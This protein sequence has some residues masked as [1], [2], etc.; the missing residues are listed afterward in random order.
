M[1]LLFC[2]FANEISFTGKPK[3]PRIRAGPGCHCVWPRQLLLSTVAAKQSRRT[4]R[5]CKQTEKWGTW[6]PTKVS[7]EASVH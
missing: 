2:C 4:F 5:W 6:Q 3:L 1:N 7:D